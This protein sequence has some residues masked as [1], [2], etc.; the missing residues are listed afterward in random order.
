MKR[1][2]RNTN[3]GNLRRNRITRINEVKDLEY[4]TGD[5]KFW[6]KN[7]KS[8]YRDII[9]YYRGEWFATDHRM[10]DDDIKDFVTM[11]ED[12]ENVEIDERKIEHEISGRF[13]S[14]HVRFE[15]D[16]DITYENSQIEE[17]EI[18]TESGATITVEVRFFGKYKIEALAKVHN[19]S[20]KKA[21][22]LLWDF[23]EGDTYDEKLDNLDDYFDELEKEIE[24]EATKRYNRIAED[25]SDIL[26]ETYEY[27]TSESYIYDYLLDNNV[28]FDSDGKIIN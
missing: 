9:D 7:D 1:L 15:C 13:R 5:I 26:S 28:I 18:L 10:F 6:K 25:L 16:M 17:V 22:N 12:D 21:V 3:R 8:V 4:A 23:L 11:V 20:N 14:N 24:T 2:L 27:V 19:L